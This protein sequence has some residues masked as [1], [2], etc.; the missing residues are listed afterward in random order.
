[1]KKSFLYITLSF[2]LLLISS[3]S[4][5][6]L[7]DNINAN[8]TQSIAA[9]SEII[10]SP[11]W[12]IADYQFVC[13]NAGNT[14]FTVVNAPAWLEV[15][16]TSGSLTKT[17]S[18]ED[19]IMYQYSTGTIRCKANPN[20][21][22]AKIGVYMD[23]IEILVNGQ[24]CYVPVMYVSEGNPSI[25]VS[26]TLTIS[27]DDYNYSYLSIGNT[28]DGILLWDV[29][30]MPEWLK[31][32][33]NRQDASSVIIPQGST[34][35]LYLTFN[36]EA[37]TS[38][39]LTGNIVLKTNDKDN[40]EVSISVTADLGNPSYVDTYNGSAK[41]DFG[42]T[43]TS[44]IFSFSNQGNGWLIWSLENLPEWLNVSQSNGVVN[45][46]NSK[47]IR[48]TCN[49]DLLPDGQ[50]NV[51]VLLKTNDPSK[52]TT[53]II[54]LARSGNNYANIQ[55]MEGNIVDATFDKNTNTMYYVTG[56]PNK[57]IA[58]DVTERLIRQEI[59]LDKAPISFAISDDF[60]RALVGQSGQISYINLQTQSVD[61]VFAVSGIAANIAFADN[62]WCIYTKPDVQWDNVYW[63]NL[64]DGTYSK[65]T[66]D[67]IY[68][69]CLV[70]KV[71]NQNYIIGSDANDV[72]VYDTNLRQQT[73]NVF[74]AFREWWFVGNNLITN[75]GSIYRI[76]DITSTDNNYSNNISAVGN[77]AYP[78]RIYY[79]IPHIDYCANTHSIFGLS[80]ETYDV[81]S[82]TIYQFEDNDYTIVNTYTYENNSPIDGS[83]LQQVQAH[84][85]FANQEGTELSVLRKGV[86]NNNW[87]IEFIQVSE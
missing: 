38:S 30:S 51:K 79:G 63:V 56:Q 2:L 62:G 3:C 23:N 47:D 43:E 71:P 25:S 28:G 78:E 45:P 1:M 86:N 70:E 66:G 14:D 46:Y 16:T 19:I 84:Y 31:V 57:L 15:E 11:A 36:S 53:E 80:M 40:P 44:Q 72:Y 5:D 12:D 73:G 42:R 10:I 33:T 32:D 83:T 60:T 49:R 87:S 61:N 68:G 39:D 48:F 81:V 74:T 85:L 64:T 18:T 41:I 37:I 8:P 52:P 6:F 77:L 58:Y 67:N 65:G 7:N 22:F 17:S 21:D 82:N 59:V 55:A 50:S 27:S 76:S 29:V 24:N 34:G 35:N 13:I 20:P 54:V 9:D 75:N 26:S 69:D 4:E